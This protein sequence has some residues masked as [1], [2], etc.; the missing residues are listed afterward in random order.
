MHVNT[1]RTTRILVADVDGSLGK[2]IQSFVADDAQVVSATDSG[3]AIDLARELQ[4]DVSILGLTTG[5]PQ[6]ELYA[7][8]R[9][10]SDGYIILLCP[11]AAPEDRIWALNE[12]A[13]DCVSR[14]FERRELTARVRAL[15]RRPRRAGN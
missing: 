1:E 14:P 7:G 11:S 13:D 4:P 8:V 9:A 5:F 6:S 12:G 10:C 15:L 3:S 2:V